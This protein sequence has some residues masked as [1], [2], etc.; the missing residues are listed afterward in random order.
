[1]TGTSKRNHLIVAVLMLL[2]LGA[3]EAFTVPRHATSNSISNT[4]STRLAAESRKANDLQNSLPFAPVQ[5]FLVAVVVAMTVALNPNPV[6][7]DGMFVKVPF[8][9]SSEARRI[10]FLLA[11]YLR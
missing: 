2:C 3:L 5:H 6:W 10:V 11:P 1:M 8:S 7:A 4:V 9:F